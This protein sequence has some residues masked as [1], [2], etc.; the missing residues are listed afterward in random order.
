MDRQDQCQHSVAFPLQSGS[1]IMMLILVQIIKMPELT[2][3]IDAHTA[4]FSGVIIDI[5]ALL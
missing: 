1:R 3:S 5:V 4:S 2:A